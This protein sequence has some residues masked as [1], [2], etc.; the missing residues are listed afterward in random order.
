M[1][2]SGERIT[3]CGVGPCFFL[4]AHGPPKHGGQKTA[5][6]T[7]TPPPTLSLALMAVPRS[8]QDGEGC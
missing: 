6:H 8:S 2:A 7:N 3:Q 5:A 4:Q 1:G